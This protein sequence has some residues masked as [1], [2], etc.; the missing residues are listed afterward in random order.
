MNI[1]AVRPMIYLRSPGERP[2][3]AALRFIILG[4]LQPDILQIGG[5]AQSKEK[6]EHFQGISGITLAYELEPLRPSLPGH[7][8]N[9][10][11]KGLREVQRILNDS[12]MQSLV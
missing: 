1:I 9:G 11:T 3:G 10:Q 8:F 12:N 2:A 7:R 5:E 4:K 6:Y